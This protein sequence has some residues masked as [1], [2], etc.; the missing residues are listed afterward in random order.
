MNTFSYLRKSFSDRNALTSRRASRMLRRG[1]GLVLLFSVLGGYMTSIADAMAPV[2]GSGFTAFRAV[3]DGM[4]FV[5]V[6]AIGARRLAARGF[7]V[8]ESMTL[9]VLAAPVVGLRPMNVPVLPDASPTGTIVAVVDTGVDPTHPWFSTHLVPGRSFAGAPE[10]FSDAH[11][12]GTHVAGIVRQAD[13]SARIMPVRAMDP[14]GRGSDSQISAGIVWAVENGAKVVNLSLGGVGRSMAIDAAIEFARSND[15]I[16]VAAAGNF[17]ESGSPVMFPAA[18][19]L[20]VAVA[21]IDGGSVAAPFSNRGAYVDVAATGVG[22]VSALPGGRFGGM[23]GTSM[24]APYAA[25]AFAQLRSLRQDLDASTLMQHIEV[26]SRDAGDPGRDD[27]Y[28]WGILDQARA[29]AE[30][31]AL[32]AAPVVAPASAGAPQFSVVPR[33]GAVVLKS[34]SMVSAMK[35]Y[36]DGELAVDS[37]AVTKQWRVP[38]FFES[39]ILIAAFDT[40]GRPYDLITLNARPKPVAAPR[41]TLSRSGGFVIATVK[42]SSTTGVLRLTAVSTDLDVVEVTLPRPGKSTSVTYRIPS[43]RKLEW[44]ARA[45]LTL[46]SSEVC[47]ELATTY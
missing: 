13:P 45:C 44:D 3:E 14:F 38:M 15:V 43:G 18:N 39:E 10:D 30:V 28:G 8:A 23:S 22:V 31:S 34:K 12:H 46:G 21:A 4:E 32:A 7:D 27:V 40:E 41:V 17:G 1:I 47:S 36:V 20:T 35:V 42:S 26:T 16:V 2:G 5:S 19:E 24:A 9:S 33:L 6:D 25:G 37:R 11:G 29:A